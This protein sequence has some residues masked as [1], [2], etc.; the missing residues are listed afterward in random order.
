[1]ACVD[2]ARARRDAR[3]VD[4]WAR[5]PAWVS[6]PR[7]G[8]GDGRLGCSRSLDP[9][10][11]RRARGNDHARHDPGPRGSLLV[12]RLAGSR[13]RASVLRASRLLVHGRT[14]CGD[15]ARSHGHGRAGRPTR[16]QPRS[17][18]AVDVAT[19]L[20]PRPGGGG[21]SCCGNRPKKRRDP[22][23]PMDG[24]NLSSP[25]NPAKRKRSSGCQVRLKRRE[26]LSRVKRSRETSLRALG[27]RRPIRDRRVDLVR[28]RAVCG[29]AEPYRGRAACR[30]ELTRPRHRVTDRR[31]RP[32]E[33][34][35]GVV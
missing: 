27:R 12:R 3:E 19:R 1:M 13:K 28:A 24:R 26:Y 17:R 20:I 7:R 29:T 22:A 33:H 21:S 34:Q 8:G 30:G 18:A 4:Q 9:P 10:R 5:R 25:T 11:P 35:Q 31:V 15:L 14:P 16:T 23:Y 2:G 6:R 32:N